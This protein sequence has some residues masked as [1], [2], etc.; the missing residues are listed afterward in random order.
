MHWIWDG[1]KCTANDMVHVDRAMLS[2]G[3]GSDIAS[4]FGSSFI[5]IT[6]FWYRDL[7]TR[8]RQ[9]LLMISISDFFNSGAYL[10]G[11]TWSMFN[12]NYS[13]CY[14]GK[15]Q[16]EIQSCVAQA[17]LNNFFTNTC[18]SFTI[19]LSFH[20]L[21]LL[22]G[23]HIFKRNLV[24]IPTVIIGL[25]V[26]LLITS[27]A[28]W[29]GWFGPGRSV[30]VGTCYIRNF[31]NSSSS[32]S[33]DKDVLIEL[34]IGK[35]WDIVTFVVISFVYILAI[36]LLCKRRRK[37]NNKSLI[38]EQDLK[39]VFVP[40]AFLFFKIWGELHLIFMYRQ[41]IPVFLYLQAVFDPGQGWINFLIYILFTS[42][43]RE[44]IMCH[45]K[46]K[47]RTYS[48]T[49]SYSSVDEQMENV[50]ESHKLESSYHLFKD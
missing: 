4:L 20:V 26:P 5:M 25:L 2:V 19:L 30:T 33:I 46:S 13:T 44:K 32:I 36:Y 23:N 24:F 18:F 43:I 12:L 1:Y 35:V 39:L 41:F 8:A 34:L 42:R 9:I 37:L 17:T 15:P 14:V 40:V 21:F 3:I 6:F 28:F 49:G 29:P 27:V 11:Q 7:Q 47:N 22:S 50:S 48:V 38:T 10:F 45:R 16:Y 31:H